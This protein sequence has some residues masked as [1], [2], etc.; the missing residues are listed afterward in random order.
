MTEEIKKLFQERLGRYQAAISLEP[1]DRIPIAPGSNY[2]AEVFSGNTHQE[3]L[4]DPQKWLEAEMAFAREFPQTDVL[5]DNRLWGPSL[6]AIGLQTYKLPGK[7]LPPDDQFQFVEQ[8]Y[9]KADEYDLL[10]EDPVDFMFTRWLPRILGEYNG[11]AEPRSYMAFLKAGLAQA[12]FVQI[13]RNRAMRLEEECGMPQ[14]MTGAFV[15]PFDALA[16]A[17]RGLTGV[18]MD[19]FRQPDKVVAACDRLVEEMAN[20][21]LNTADPLKRYPIFVPTHKACFLSPEQFDTFYWPSFKRVLEILTSAGYKI[22]AYLEGDWGPHWH[23]LLELPKGTIICDIDNQ[24]DIFQAKRDIGHHQ[25]L[26][27]GIPDSQFILG[28]PEDVR[29][30]VKE[31]CDTLGQGGGFLIGGGCNIPHTTRPE[32]Y[33]AM[34]DAVLEFG[35]YDETVKPLPKDTAGPVNVKAFDFPKKLTPWEVKKKEIGGSVPGDENLIQ[36]P[37]DRLEAMAYAWLW[38]WTM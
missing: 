10:I 24:G 21:A 12:Q 18:I 14:P 13:M 5:R 8:E 9:M 38:Q 6:D 17:M 36:E 2:F 4:Y 34:V 1:T 20:F 11:R 26:A 7:D 23:H 37:W 25:C 30:R 35:R 29:K 28:T 22:R 15:A 32:N 16:D 3:T 31:L 19:T 27:G 33:Q